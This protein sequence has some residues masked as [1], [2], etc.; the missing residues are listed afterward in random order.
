MQKNVCDLKVFSTNGFN[1]E[2]VSY[3]PKLSQF[4]KNDD[5][6]FLESSDELL[7]K[8]DSSLPFVTPRTLKVVPTV[9]SLL[10]NFFFSIPPFHHGELLLESL[11]FPTCFQCYYCL[12][13]FVIAI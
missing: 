3:M 7:P 12:N 9:S 8:E 4:G 5:K 10:A 2:V 11:I 13:Y 1:E 6:P